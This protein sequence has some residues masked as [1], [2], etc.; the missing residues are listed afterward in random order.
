MA[1][2]L[3]LAQEQVN[4]RQKPIQLLLGQAIIFSLLVEM[5]KALS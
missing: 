5:P 1:L 2:K 3:I 4:H